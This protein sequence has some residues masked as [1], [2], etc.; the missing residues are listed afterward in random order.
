MRLG[1]IMLVVA[2]G[3][4]ADAAGADALQG[5]GDTRYDEIASTAAGRSYDIV[6]G[7]PAGYDESGDT[8]YP[9]VYLLDGGELYPMLSAYRRYLRFGEE[10]PD[11]ILVAISYGTDDW[12]NG[13]DRGH[14]FTAPS[15][16]REHWGGA[17]DFQR[18]LG[19]ELIPK[20]ETEYRSRGDRRIVFG[21]SLGGQFVLHAALTEPGLFWGHIASNPALHRN[22]PFFLEFRGAAPARG[23]GGD[24]GNDSDRPRLFVASG[25]DDD[26]RF[27]TPALAWMSH[28]SAA[29]TRPW[30]LATVTLD[31]HSHFSA[32]P[33][34]FRQGL[35]W[36]F[37]GEPDSGHRR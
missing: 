3:R 35:A 7:L 17:P 6:I 11:L 4:V 15:A 28:W 21:Q 9:T 20:I 32:P 25:S 23:N 13:N 27:R 31:G 18:F 22:L 24:G 36:L 10:I 8:R 33:A 29:D 2:I 37:S 5:L 19:D 16:E 14:D 30:E 34:A 26:E 12:R 1:T